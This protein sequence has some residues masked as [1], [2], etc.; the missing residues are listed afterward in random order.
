MFGLTPFNKNQ[1]RRTDDLDTFLDDFFSDRLFPLRSLRH[2]TFKLDVKDEGNAYFVEAELP[3]IKKE[4]IELNYQDG[5]LSISVVREAS[6]E[7]EQK[8]YI[9]KERR[10][11]KMCRSLRLGDINM[12]QVEASLKDGILEIKAPKQQEVEQKTRIMI[13]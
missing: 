2:D 9:H 10:V 6:N 5:I 13:K 3:G 7:E 1:V 4:E 8:N 12:E 11:S